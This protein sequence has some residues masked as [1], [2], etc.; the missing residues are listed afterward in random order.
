MV[1]FFKTEQFT[2]KK[3]VRGCGLRDAPAVVGDEEILLDPAAQKSLLNPR[4][5]TEICARV[6]FCFVL[7]GH[8][9][10]CTILV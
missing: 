5:V 7:V 6:K 10:D 3:D 1:F 9:D 4:K 8:K 2:L